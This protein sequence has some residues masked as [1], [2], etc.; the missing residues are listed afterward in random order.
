MPDL[1]GAVL[2]P[3]AA[4]Q[5]EAPVARSAFT[6]QTGAPTAPSV[7]TAP[8][9]PVPAVFERVSSATATHAVEAERE[10]ARSAGYAAGFAAGASEAARAAQVEAE[11]VAARRASEDARRAAEHAAALDALGRAAQ[12]A[13]ARTAPVLAHAEARLHA[14]ALELAAAV[15]GTELTD[16]ERSARAALARVLGHPLVPGVHTVRLH[17]RDVAALQ[18][19]GGVPAAAGVEVVADPALAPGDAVGEHPDGYL[20][21]RIDAALDRARAVLLAEVGSAPALSAAGRE[22]AAAGH[23]LPHQRGY[24]A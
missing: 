12:V 18:A 14:A 22:H 13:A 6:A 3:S 15:L 10:R 16:G 23:V 7:P 2:R 24:L 4:A 20:D 5:S 1:F 21:G 11:H 19:A 9:A 8:S 17:P